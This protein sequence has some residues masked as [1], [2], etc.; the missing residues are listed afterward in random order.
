MAA[1]SSNESSNDIIMPVQPETELMNDAGSAGQPRRLTLADARARRPR[2][3]AFRGS[4][5]RVDAFELEVVEIGP[6]TDQQGN[7]V[8]FL[9]RPT[10]GVSLHSGQIL[11][12]PWGI[13]KIVR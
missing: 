5:I 13:C 12:T 8:T 6:Y 3:S 10:D 7:I 11:G 9:A 1:R 4:R 2:L